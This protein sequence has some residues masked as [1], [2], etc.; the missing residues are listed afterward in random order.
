RSISFKVSSESSIWPA[1]S[2]PRR[3]LVGFRNSPPRIPLTTCPQN[4]V[5]PFA[6]GIFLPSFSTVPR[7]RS[8]AC[9]SPAPSTRPWSRQPFFHLGQESPGPHCRNDAPKKSR[10]RSDR[11]PTADRPLPVVLLVRHPRCHQ[12]PLP[13]T[14]PP[15]PG[16]EASIGRVGAHRS[17]SGLGI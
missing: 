4:R 7:S 2:C 12:W 16:A 8:R 3:R 10:T 15:T 6:N 17:V 14:Y 11:S 9:R 1:R 13:T 5:N